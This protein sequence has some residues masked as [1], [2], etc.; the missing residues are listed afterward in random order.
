MEDHDIALR[1]FTETKQYTGKEPTY[2][3][4]PDRILVFDTETTNDE[5]Q[6]LLFGHFKIYGNGILEHQGIFYGDVVKEKELKILQKYCTQNNID[7]YTVQQFIDEI[8]YYQIY[9]RKAVC[10]GFNLPFDISRLA[11]HFGEST[12]FKGGFSFKLSDNPKYPWLRIMHIDSTMSFI[13]FN[14]S[15]SHRWGNNR[16]R[17]G[18]NNFRGNFLDLRTL[19]FALTNRKHSLRSAGELFKAEILKTES[20]NWLHTSKMLT[21]HNSLSGK[22]GPCQVI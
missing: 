19:V 13:Q 8:F 20:D 5:L 6:N 2:E 18:S 16:N 4:L 14:N 15:P 1:C 11:F 7:L 17:K 3:I 10:L 9:Y 12:R 22:Y 21:E